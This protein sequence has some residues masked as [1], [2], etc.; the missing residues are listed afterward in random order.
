M[1]RAGGGRG[2]DVTP[3]LTGRDAGRDEAEIGDAGNGASPFGADL[4]AST[5]NPDLEDDP[6]AYGAA[7]YFKVGEASTFTLQVTRTELDANLP[8]LD[9]TVTALGTGLNFGVRRTSLY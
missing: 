7:F 8:G 1:K 2:A 5:P 3:E 4:T 9:R 6:R